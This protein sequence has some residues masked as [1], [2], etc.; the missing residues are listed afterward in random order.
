MRR[1][2]TPNQRI[3]TEMLLKLIE[4]RDT[5]KMTPDK[6]SFAFPH[7]RVKATQH[8][9]PDIDAHPDDYIREKTELWRQTWIISPLDDVIAW[10]KGDVK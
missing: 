6:A 5:A 7:D 9:G 10:A 3:P 4:A 1:K 2:L 8:M